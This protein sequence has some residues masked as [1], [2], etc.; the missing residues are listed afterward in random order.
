MRSSRASALRWFVLDTHGLTHATP[1][2]VYGAYAPIACPSGVAA[3]GRDPDSATQVWSAEVGY[4]ARSLV[5]R[6]PP[7]HRLRP[8][9]AK[10]S[11][12]FVSG[13]RRTPDRPQVPPHHR[14]HRLEGALRAR[15]RPGPGPR[16]TRRTSSRRAGPRSHGSAAAWTARRSSSAPTMPSS[17]AI[18]GSR[19]QTGSRQ[20]C[21]AARRPPRSWRRRPCRTTSTAT[22]RSSGPRRRRARGVARGT[23]RVWLSTVE[24]LDLSPPPRAPRDR[25]A[26]LCCDARPGRPGG[27]RALTQALRELLLAQASDWAFMMARGPRSNTRTRRTV[28]HLRSIVG[29]SATPSSGARSTIRRS[30]R[31]RTRTP[32]FPALDHRVARLTSP[33]VSSLSVAVH[34]WQLACRPRWSRSCCCRWR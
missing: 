17:S 26:R 19:D 3:F 29:G 24:R 22:R 9:R 27:R 31:S 21:A 6:L 34:S 18:G 33:L 12:P 30:P 23:T 7:R 32:L 2:P 25:L 5:S 8:A 28:E 4:P 1:Q 11:R 20:S 13:D 10:P 16:R 15:A 14:R